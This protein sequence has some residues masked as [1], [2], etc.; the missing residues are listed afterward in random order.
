VA[1]DVSVALTP[2][3]VSEMRPALE[4][5]GPRIE[6]GD[7]IAVTEYSVATYQFYA[8]TLISP[9]T[10]MLGIALYASSEERLKSLT[11]TARK[12][13][14]RRIWLVVAL[15][16]SK[17]RLANNAPIVFEWTG[18]DTRVILFD[19]TSSKVPSKAEQ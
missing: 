18:R 4:Q 2:F 14:Y 3:F 6:P 11:E 10:P 13:G 12:N 17:V 1:K 8:P 9:G 7:A 19:F 5:I 16:A 15:N